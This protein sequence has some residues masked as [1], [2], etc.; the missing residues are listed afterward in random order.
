MLQSKA[1]DVVVA[2]SALVP[3]GSPISGLVE[4]PPWDWS[5]NRPRQWLRRAV[6]TVR[7]LMPR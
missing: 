2:M 7:N 5:K 6:A 4:M 1:E 3:Y